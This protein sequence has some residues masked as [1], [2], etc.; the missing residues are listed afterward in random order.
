MLLRIL[1]TFFLVFGLILT[2][3]FPWLVKA[4]PHEGKVALQHYSILFGSYLM[5]T[6]LCFVGAA[7]CAILM[8]RQVREAYR[9]QSRQNLEELVESALRQ[10]QK[11]GTKDES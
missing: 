5:V 6:M 4:R 10:H 7:I 3:C 8:V 2:L 9:L 11:P 1:T